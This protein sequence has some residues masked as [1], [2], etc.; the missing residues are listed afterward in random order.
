MLQSASLAARYSLL[1]PR[2]FGVPPPLSD[3]LSE[4]H[5]EGLAPLESM[6]P[7][8]ILDRVNEI[9]KYGRMARRN[10]GLSE[11]Q[12]RSGSINVKVLNLSTPDCLAR[13]Y[14][15]RSFGAYAPDGRRFTFL[16]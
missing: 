16:A 11:N 3:A 7:D 15:S 13:A 14:S 4:C 1:V 2:L 8:S 10:D 6:Q 9:E 12:G 5:R